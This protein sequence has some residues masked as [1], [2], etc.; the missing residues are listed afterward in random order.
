VNPVIVVW[1]AL[2]SLNLRAVDMQ[3]A[4][5]PLSVDG[6]SM[7]LV[8]LP[9]WLW[10]DETA[11]TWGPVTAS[12]SDG[13]VSVTVTARVERVEWAMGDGT[14]IT[15]RGP[16]TRFDP[17]VYG[18]DVES[19]DCGHVYERVSRDPAGV[20]S[21]TAT[22]YWVANWS[23]GADAGTIPFDSQP[24]SRSVSA[25]CRSSAP[26]VPARFAQRV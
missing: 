16:G 19:P 12:A 14:V 26:A 23:S 5:K 8:G 25:R 1:R 7:G 15:C 6:D 9:V 4:P 2:A 11:I 22:S 13:P 24:A 17:D 21:V 18:V 10:V 3:I 20:Y